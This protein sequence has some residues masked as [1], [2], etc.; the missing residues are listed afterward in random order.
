[1]VSIEHELDSIKIS[2]NLVLK[3]LKKQ[4]K[5]EPQ[6]CVRK[7]QRIVFREP[8]PY[9]T[10]YYGNDNSCNGDSILMDE[11]LANHTH[12]ADRVVL[13]CFLDNMSSK[14][15]FK[16][17]YHLRDQMGYQVEIYTNEREIVFTK[18]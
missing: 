18:E 2:L 13:D 10:V 16:I 5:E 11:L 17:I 1:M 7:I 14:K 8:S 15:T 9:V 3:E 12:F 6:I 4:Q